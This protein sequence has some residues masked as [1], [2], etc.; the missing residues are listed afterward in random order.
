M[1]VREVMSHPVITV[2]AWTTIQETAKILSGRGF[3]CVPVL[4][5]DDTLVG[6]VSEG[7]L[8]RKALT[9][10]PRRHPHLF[11]GP[12]QKPGI[13]ADVMTRV[14][15][16]LTPGADVADAAR[17]MVDERIR[18]LP[19]VDGANVVGVI[20]RRDLLR[21]SLIRD[22]SALR[23]DAI[24]ALEAFAEPDRWTVTVQAAVADVEDFR[25]SPED[26][27]L[28]HR[29]VSKVPGIVHVQVHHETSD[30]F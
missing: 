1:L 30:P 21:A 27:E 26:R 15:E 13:V 10:D 5:D 25:D 23:E 6:I 12:G 28:A 7:D 18:A 3:T 20:T 14:V 8:L 22:D 4:D 29:L 9:P 24:R 11:T 16:S 2:R 17:I 19:I